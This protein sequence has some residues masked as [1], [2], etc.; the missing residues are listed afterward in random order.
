MTSGSSFFTEGVSEASAAQHS[1]SQ[2]KIGARRFAQ[3]T[4]F[5]LSS[6]FTHAC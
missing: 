4:M 1:H 6:R 3:M 5:L 2:P